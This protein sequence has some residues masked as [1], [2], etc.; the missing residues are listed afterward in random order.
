MWRVIA[1]LLCTGT[2]WAETVAD[3]ETNMGTLTVR[4]FDQDAPQTV[5]QFKAL[6]NE[7][8][9]DGKTFYR[10]VRGHV[11]QAGGNN[12]DDPITK[13]RTVPAEFNQHPHVRGALGLA[14]DTD[15]DSGSTEI[16]LCDAP[17]PHLDGR[18]TVFGELIAGEAVLE[19]IATVAVDEK[20]LDEDKKIAFHQPKAPVVIKQVRLREQP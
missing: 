10:V 17:R 5:A 2:V 13:T 6:I 15:P 3:I 9:Y 14:R 8:W 1:L 18:Y 19:A 12:D 11:I 4:F 7:Q 16:Y 20:W